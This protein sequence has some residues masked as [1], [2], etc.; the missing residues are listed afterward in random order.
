MAYRRGVTSYLR[1]VGSAALQGLATGLFV[2][3]AALPMAQRRTARGI[4]VVGLSAAAS[5]GDWAIDR[6][7]G[8]RTR[9]APPGRLPEPE[10]LRRPSRRQL[11]ALGA[12][13]GVT[14]ASILVRRRLERRWLAALHAQGHPH[15]YRVLGVRMGLLSFAGALPA[16]LTQ[17]NIRR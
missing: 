16:R 15:P 14:A 4:T 9:S 8:D 12:G 2:A 17:A 5:L 10:E 11:A 13:L 1:A 6:R 7:A 3:A